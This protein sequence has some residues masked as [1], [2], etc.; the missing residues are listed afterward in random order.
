MICAAL[1]AAS[2]LVVRRATPLTTLA[3]PSTSRPLKKVTLPVGAAA[4]FSGTSWPEALRNFS[5][6][7]DPPVP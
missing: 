7:I 1:C 3:V 2:A 5:P 6:A 4:A